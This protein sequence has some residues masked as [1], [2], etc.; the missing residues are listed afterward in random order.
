MRRIAGSML[1]TKMEV[2]E[3]ASRCSRTI[4]LQTSAFTE[5]W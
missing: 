3:G 1:L 5:V 2:R 4:K